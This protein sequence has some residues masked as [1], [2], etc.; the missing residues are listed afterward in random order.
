MKISVCDIC[1]STS[2]QLT[3]S[4]YSAGF[5]GATK[6]DLCYTHRHVSPKSAKEVIKKAQEGFY[7][8]CKDTI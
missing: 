7:G 6:V 2:G 8:T 1:L 4:A 5:T 3:P